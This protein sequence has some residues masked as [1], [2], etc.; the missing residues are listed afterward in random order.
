MDI[1]D[2]IIAVVHVTYWPTTTGNFCTLKPIADI[3]GDEIE[4]DEFYNRGRVWW[5]VRNEDLSYANLGRIISV[6]IEHSISFDQSDP[7]KDF[8]Q[9]AFGTITGTENYL[10]EIIEMDASLSPISLVETGRIKCN[11]PIRNGAVFC[12]SGSNIIGPFTVA[13]TE[14][15]KEEKVAVFLNLSPGWGNQQL[16]LMEWPEFFKIAQPHSVP[17]KIFT[18]THERNPIDIEYHFFPR[19][20]LDRLLSSAIGKEIDSRSDKM[21]VSEVVKDLKWSRA[22]KQSL[23]RL[24]D[25]IHRAD[26]GLD[27]VYKNKDRILKIVKKVDENEKV[28][29][30]LLD[31]LLEEDKLQALLQNRINERVDNYIE[32]NRKDLERQ[33]NEKI[34]HKKKELSDLEKS[35]N[36]LQEQIETEKKE[37]FQEY[38]RVLHNK[39][40]ELDQLF[41]Q[42]EE[43]FLNKEKEFIGKQEYLSSLVNK[44]SQNRD[45]IV[46]SLIGLMPVLQ[47]M[48]FQIISGKSDEATQKEEKQEIIQHVNINPYKSLHGIPKSLSESEFL[49][50]WLML[51]NE[52][53]FSYNEKD[54]RNFH[55]CTKSENFNILTGPSGIG[56]S[57]LP[58]FYS[59]AL[60][61][62]AEGK[63]RYLSVSVKPGWLD[64]QELIGYFNSL[65]GRF[66]PSNS[67][68][69]QFLVASHKESIEP[70]SGIHICCLD[71]MNLSY[72]EQYFA[73][74]L[75]L[76][77]APQQDRQI[78]FF[79]NNL[80]RVDDPYRDFHQIH[81]PSSLRFC[82]TVNVDE[83]TKFFSPKVLDRVHII[84]MGYVALSNINSWIEHV[85]DNT[86][87]GT[88]ISSRIY[89]SWSQD[90]GL[91]QEYVLKSICDIESLLSTMG[92]GIS[93]RT[94]KSIC[95]Y[96]S[97]ARG[98]ME[99]DEEAMDY[100]IFQK[101]L[102]ALRGHSTQ[103]R[104]MLFKLIEITESKNYT[105]SSSRIRLIADAP[106]AMDFF[107]YSMA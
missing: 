39:K 90:P 104:E 50:H 61:G 9:V 23:T 4:P 60:H 78:R 18:E 98:V 48:G 58:R 81:I 51:M 7:N 93:P 32:A 17:M 56:K 99:S 52:S 29:R 97:N 12:R 53:G 30:E 49:D 82:G 11:H 79:D 36:V 101:I 42:R 87:T 5:K 67:G 107:N 3:S 1:G 85:P 44:L 2:R 63:M 27:R 100:A 77:Q 73:D 8:F 6:E 74:F 80:C 38:E 91:V 26:P 57:S 71:E 54:L 46:A 103:F 47:E 76:L 28:I 35:I 105:K 59:L 22:D 40:A 45:E 41:Q 62:N 33:A 66:Q 34:F 75:V 10:A 55:V 72:V 20:R 83:T 16:R 102:P 15:I 13:G 70:E 43:E 89:F 21:V 64:S 84:E 95:R 68:F 19:D 65:D 86:E 88:P 31:T 24:V 96:V 106:I 14:A 94:F 92:S 25:E 37:K 69:Y